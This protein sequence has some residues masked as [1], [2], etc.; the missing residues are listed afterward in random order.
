M[1][2][3]IKLSIY[4]IL[5]AVILSSCGSPGQSAAQK[6]GLYHSVEKNADASPLVLDSEI[7]EAVTDLVKPLCEHYGIKKFDVPIVYFFCHDLLDRKVYDAVVEIDPSKNDISAIA[8]LCYAVK[9]I[10]HD[11]IAGK[12]SSD[13]P[14]DVLIKVVVA[15]TETGTYSFKEADDGTFSLVTGNDVLFN[16][17]TWEEI[18]AINK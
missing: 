11:N 4:L 12:L 10:T 2:Q 18:D 15:S 7:K 6:A 8:H 14:D 17:K 3:Y 16:G 13:L 5:V 9:D 1:K